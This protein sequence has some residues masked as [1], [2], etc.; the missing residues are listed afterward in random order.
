[1]HEDNPCRTVRSNSVEMNSVERCAYEFRPATLGDAVF[2]AAVA[3]QATRTLR[4]PTD[5]FDEGGLASAGFI[6]WTEEQVRGEVFP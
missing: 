3:L 4:G 5:D 6:S 2:P 1:L